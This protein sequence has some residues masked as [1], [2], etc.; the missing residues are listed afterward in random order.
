MKIKIGAILPCRSDIMPVQPFEH[1]FKGGTVLFGPPQQHM[2]MAVFNRKRN[3]NDPGVVGRAYGNQVEGSII[4]ARANNEVA[5]VGAIGAN[6]VELFG[7]H[8]FR[9]RLM[10]TPPFAMTADDLSEVKLAYFRESSKENRCN[11]GFRQIAARRTL[12][13]RAGRQVTLRQEPKSGCGAK[14]SAPQNV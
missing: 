8:R 6:V 11:L 13:E 4:I 12:P 2:R 5:G 1:F 9:S 10:L 3:D 7:M 14:K